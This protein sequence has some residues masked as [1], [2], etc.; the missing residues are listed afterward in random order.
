MPPEKRDSIERLDEMDR[1]LQQSVI[2]KKNVA[3]LKSLSV[4]KDPKVAERAAVILEIARVLPGKRSRWI[5]LARRHRSLFDRAVEHF[6][7]DFFEDLLAG[8]RF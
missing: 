7:V 4:H 3:R 2:S 8:C 5:K 6:G 1:F